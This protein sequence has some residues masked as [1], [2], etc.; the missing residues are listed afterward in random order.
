MNMAF[1]HP[2]RPSLTYLNSPGS[3]VGNCTRELSIG[4]IADAINRA[5][6]EVDDVVCVIENT[7]S[8]VKNSKIYSGYSYV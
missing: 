2:K 4:Y 5:H 6:K 1:H 3:T 7:V 8:T